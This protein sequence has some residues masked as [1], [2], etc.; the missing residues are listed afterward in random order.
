MTDQQRREANAAVFDK[1]AMLHERV[2]SQGKQV[3]RQH[4]DAA[5]ARRAAARIRKGDKS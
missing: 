2:A 1:L 4:S 3:N 5:S